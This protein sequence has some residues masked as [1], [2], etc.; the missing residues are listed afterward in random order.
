MEDLTI[1]EIKDSVQPWVVAVTQFCL[2]QKY[3]VLFVF[4]ALAGFILGVLATIVLT[5]MSSDPGREKASY[6]M[7]TNTITPSN[8]DLLTSTCSTGQSHRKKAN[9]KNTVDVAVQA[10]PSS[11]F[12]VMA[13]EVIDMYVKFEK[14]RMKRRRCF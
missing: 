7:P 1:K 11:V 6:N 13:P 4:A 9:R 14:E 10:N 8:K 5:W 12:P 3:T 2:D